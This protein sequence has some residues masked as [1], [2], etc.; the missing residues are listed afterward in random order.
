MQRKQIVALLA[1]VSVGVGGGVLGA[2]LA[3]AAVGAAARRFLEQFDDQDDQ[4]IELEQPALSATRHGTQQAS[5]GI[6]LVT[7][8]ASA[9]SL[10]TPKEVVTS[11]QAP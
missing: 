5:R 11:A 7:S 4:D 8:P 6:A 3:W 9:P 10:P 2:L 1:G